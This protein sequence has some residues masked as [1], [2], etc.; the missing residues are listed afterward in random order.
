MMYQNFLV[1]YPSV[2]LELRSMLFSAKKSKMKSG[3]AAKLR[4]QFYGP[5]PCMGTQRHFALESLQKAN[6]NI[7][8]QNKI[9]Q[10]RTQ[11]NKELSDQIAKPVCLHWQVMEHS[12]RLERAAIAENEGVC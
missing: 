6:L 7:V 12:E 10:R 9:M 3:R 1:F 11:I 8:L 4:G 2:H 5:S